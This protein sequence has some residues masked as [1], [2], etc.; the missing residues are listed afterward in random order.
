MG[1]KS[2]SAKTLRNAVICS[3]GLLCLVGC[4]RKNARSEPVADEQ[5]SSK[6]AVAE[7]GGGSPNPTP[8][9]G[10]AATT[11]AANNPAQGGPA[12]GSGEQSKTPPAEGG[13]RGEGMSGKKGGFAKGGPR[14]PVP[15]Q[16]P[17][18]KAA[19]EMI[20]RVG[21]KATRLAGTPGGPGALGIFEMPGDKA[22]EADLEVL[23]Q[24][25][26]VFDLTLSG[27]AFGDATAPQILQF[28]KLATVRLKGKTFTDK[29]LQDLLPHPAIRI[30]V[31]DDTAIGAE[32]FATLGKSQTVEYL[33]VIHMALTPEVLT[34][35]K[36]LR[37]LRDIRIRDC[38]VDDAEVKKLQELL[39]ECDIVV[40]TTSDAGAKE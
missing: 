24:L 7:Q 22:T 23:K 37:G 11:P 28:T 14:G 21:G 3:M 15:L 25:P 38:Q 27:P 40:E 19:Q 6:R 36:E 35:M 8:T 16:N 34:G 29:I 31:L 2:L 13:M 32:G 17:A 5:W 1:D 10:E 9:A 12:A 30:I 39:P 18:E 33:D 4:S 26:G 20:E